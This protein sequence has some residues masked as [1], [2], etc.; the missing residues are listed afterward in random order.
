MKKV[1]VHISTGFAGCTHEDE[2][3]V[4]DN[5]TAEEIEDM[6]MTSVWNHIDVSWQFEGQ[7]D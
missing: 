4:E 6:V 7:E 1:K 5:I 2:F 3:E